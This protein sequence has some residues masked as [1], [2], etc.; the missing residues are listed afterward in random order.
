MEALQSHA[1]QDFAALVIP[2]PN[3][4]GVLE[5]VDVLTD[6]AHA[7]GMLAIAVVN[8]LVMAVIAAG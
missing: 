6:F 8:P 5:D 2:Q 7:N 3:F 1:G 4:F